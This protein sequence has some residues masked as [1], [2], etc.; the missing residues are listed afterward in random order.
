MAQAHGH[1]RERQR[2]SGQQVPR[3]EPEAEHRGGHEC[4]H[5]HLRAE[6]GGAQRS[7]QQARANPGH[8]LRQPLTMG[9]PQPPQAREGQ[10]EQR[11][12]A[13]QPV[14]AIEEQG[15]QPVGALQVAARRVGVGRALAGYVRGVRR[16]AAV[17][18]LVERHVERHRE[19]RQFDGSDRERP[20]LRPPELARCHRGDHHAGR[21]ELGAEPRQGAE[22][23]ETQERVHPNYALVEAQGQQRGAREC[24]ARGELGVDRAAVGHEWR[25]EPH[26]ERGSE[27]PRVGC[28][29]QRKPVRQRQRQRGDRS[30]EQ[31]HSLRAAD[32]IRRRDQEW[33]ADAMWLV[34]PALGP[35][36]VAVE[37]VR[38][39]AGVGALGVLVEHVDVAVLDDR[40]GGQQVVRL[41]AAVV[42]GAERVQAQRGRVGG[43]Q[44][45]PEGEGATHRRRTL[46]SCLCDD[47]D[48][49]LIDRHLAAKALAERGADHPEIVHHQRRPRHDALEVLGAADGIDL[50]LAAAQ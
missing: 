5:E 2:Q 11:R 23:R 39:E 6:C 46:T 14:V 21:H 30:E 41:V 27:C 17:E 3:R 29:A 15:D 8:R 9:A 48:L 37:F 12:P 24:G 16:G 26:R 10:H 45:E 22:Q 7:G 43:E 38:I 4:G 19:E 36:S 13:Q 42:G 25:A 44:Q 20:P 1:Q 31:L 33:K 28:H 32:G 35:A 40:L 47:G 34:Q 49:F 50:I 18:R